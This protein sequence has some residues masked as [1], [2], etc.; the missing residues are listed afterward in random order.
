MNGIRATNSNMLFRLTN[1]I[2]LINLKDQIKRI[3]VLVLGRESL[4]IQ[5]ISKIYSFK[6]HTL[7]RFYGYYR[8]NAK[9][10]FHQAKRDH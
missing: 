6:P 10:T 8:L 7:D 9:I 2:N 4:S 1:P 3:V 5:E